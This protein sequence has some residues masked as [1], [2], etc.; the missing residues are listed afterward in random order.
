MNKHTATLTI[1]HDG[2]TWVIQSQ[3]AARDGKVFCHLASTTRARVQRNGRV[4]V[5]IGDWIDADAILSAAIVAEESRRA[6][7][8]SE[9]AGPCVSWRGAGGDI[10]RCIYCSSKC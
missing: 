5:Q 7:C 8:A 6:K 4:P 10:G 2:D 3:G 9:H 1:A